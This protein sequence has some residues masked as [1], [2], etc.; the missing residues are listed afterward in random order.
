MTIERARVV[1]LRGPNA[2][3]SG[4][5][6]APRCVLT[7]HHVVSG[8]ESL[9]A[10]SL[11][12]DDW[13]HAKVAWSDQSLDAALVQLNPD[14]NAPS[15]ALR[16]T[17][18]RRKR[19]PGNP[20]TVQ[21]IGFPRV[22]RTETADEVRRDT[23]Q[24]E[25]LLKPLSYVK[26]GVLAFDVTGSRLR[27]KTSKD[28]EAWSGMSG[29]AV[30]AADELVGLIVEVPTEWDGRFLLRPSWDLCARDDFK[31]AFRDTVGQLLPDD[32][33]ERLAP[34]PLGSPE[35]YRVRAT[36]F[37]EFYL[38][39][40]DARQP[41]GGRDV[42]L[43]ALD[44]WLADDQ[45]SRCLVVGEAGRG[46]SAL[47]VHWAA[48]L[49]DDWRVV[50][51]PISLRVET[52]RAEFALQALAAQLAHAEGEML[53]IPATDRAGYFYGKVSDYLAPSRG[54]DYVLVIIDG[55][56]EGL[57]FEAFQPLLPKRLPAGVKVL[58][59]ARFTKSHPTEGEWLEYL[60]WPKGEARSRVLR[61][62]NLSQDGI[63]D[64]LKQMGDPLAPFSTQT[65]VLVELHA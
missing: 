26:E 44:A 61:L 46:K 38:S 27:T 11:D 54:A 28:V 35:G 43:D 2:Y 18:V 47:L 12:S 15:P 33:F 37:L 30:F 34:A 14:A 3:G 1:E 53:E 29:A 62:E 59:S 64:V 40:A 55:L 13:Q 45:A 41:F 24:V 22:Q 19:L 23:E 10:R 39:T 20:L 5:L 17:Q 8:V 56:D 25:G 60:Q 58:A 49:P 48:E 9:E 6:I 7:A 50:F 52:H 65:D 51:I 32:P 36:N 57:G 42:E 16:L 31:K 63:A 4:Y 21:A